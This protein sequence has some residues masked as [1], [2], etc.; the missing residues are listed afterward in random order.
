MKL[1]QIID[2]Y[3][4]ITQLVQP[5]ITPKEFFWVLNRP[6][7]EQNLTEARIYT[8]GSQSEQGVGAAAV[9]GEIVRKV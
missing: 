3:R 7:V 5:Y 2:K 9:M 4:I 1:R 8:H 6:D